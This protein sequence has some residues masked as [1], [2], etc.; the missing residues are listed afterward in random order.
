MPASPPLLFAFKNAGSLQLRDSLGADFEPLPPV[1]SPDRFETWRTAASAAEG[2][3]KIVVAP[4]L[5]DPTSGEI[6]TLDESSWKHRF[7]APYL[8]W[9]FA[10]AAASRRCTDGGA[11]VALVQT[12]AVLDAAGWTPELAIADGVLALVRSI[13]AAEGPRGVR[14]NLVTTPIGL[15]EGN[16][17]APAPPLPGFPGTLEQHVAGALR[18]FLSHDAI[19]LTGRVLSADGGRSL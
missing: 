2:R 12:P 3:D 16:I 4:W 15:V 19:G 9:N 7:E 6:N 10:L 11:I 5:D 17:V 8:L 18:T 14:V 13:A 1:D